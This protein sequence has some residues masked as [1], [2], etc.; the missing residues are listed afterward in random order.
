MS[1]LKYN[2]GRHLASAT[3]FWR[4]FAHQLQTLF[5]EPFVMWRNGYHDA[6]GRP[7]SRSSMRLAGKTG[8]RV[9]DG[10]D[11]PRS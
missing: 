6:S 11:A 3:K 8:I 7:W 1:S 10:A 9:A 2:G 5:V 4:K